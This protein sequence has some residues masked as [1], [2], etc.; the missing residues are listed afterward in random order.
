MSLVYAVV[1]K[2]AAE[3]AVVKASE[4]SYERRVTCRWALAGTV[5]A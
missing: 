1:R 5:V 3:G 2:L 4:S